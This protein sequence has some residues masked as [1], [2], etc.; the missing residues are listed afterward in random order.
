MKSKTP[1]FIKGKIKIDMNKNPLLYLIL[2]ACFACCMQSCKKK[3]SCEDTG[4]VSMGRRYYF[5][6]TV[7]DTPIVVNVF[8]ADGNQIFKNRIGNGG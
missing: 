2:F 4:G 8:D 3:S 6:T 7:Q 5:W 1:I